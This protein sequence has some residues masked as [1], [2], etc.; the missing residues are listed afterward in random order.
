M[1]P[2]PPQDVAGIGHRF[3]QPMNEGEP[4]HSGVDLQAQEGT[5]TVSPEDGI[6]EEV[7]DDPSGLGL[8]VIVRD[9]NGM[10][11]KLGH[12]SSTDAYRGMVVAKGQNLARVGSS[13]NTTGSHLHWAVRDQAGQPTDPTPA[14][15]AMGGLPPVPGTEMMGPPG[16]SGS[17]PGMAGPP[18][19]APPGAPPPGA[20]GMPPEGPPPG[21]I[22]KSLGMGQDNWW[23]PLLGGAGHADMGAGAEGG[24]GAGEEPGYMGITPDQQAGID[25]ENKRIDM[26]AEN[27]RRDNETRRYIADKEH[28]ARMKEIDQNWLIH[29]DDDKRQ[30]EINAE[31]TRHNQAQEQIERDRIQADITIQQMRDANAIKLQQMEQGNAIYM[32]QGEQAFQDWQNQQKYRMDILGSA[33]KNPWLQKLSGMTPGPG[34]QGQEIG[35]QNISNLV[36]QVLQPYDPRAWGAQNAPS[37]AGL[38]GTT[39]GGPEGELQTPGGGMFQQAGTPGAEGGGAPQGGAQ[40]G[41]QAAGAQPTAYMQGGQVYQGQVPQGY[42]YQ[43]GTG[44]PDYMQWRGWDPFQKA[45]YRTN[46]EALGPGAW[47]AEQSRIGDQFAQAGG[48]PEVTRMQAAAS[49]AAGRAGMEMTGEMFGQTGEQFWQDQSKQ[50]GQAKAPT[51][52][53]NLQGATGVR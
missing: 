34:Y 17:P 26:E 53:Q 19:G 39:A 2:L 33:L 50:W 25:A 9:K 20:A 16:G 3:G 35:G 31:N 47:E 41:A 44:T 45:A 40:P 18:T 28:E 15:G 5:P 51:V 36:N 10:Q 48:T 21:E 6:I 29:Q 4:F 46:I 22:A 38:G 13:G 24:M 14:L 27:N 32:Q 1:P 37:V 42:N 11:H 7:R 49:D 52:R 12:L 43:T 8:T 23:E 30:Q